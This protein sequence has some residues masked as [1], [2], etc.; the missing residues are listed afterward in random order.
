MV[1]RMLF[2]GWVDFGLGFA[3]VASRWDLVCGGAWSVG[4][5]WFIV[6]DGGW[7]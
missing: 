5:F 1:V 3:V 4:G 7:V 6:V 2:F